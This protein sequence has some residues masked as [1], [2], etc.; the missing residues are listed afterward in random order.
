MNFILIIQPDIRPDRI[1]GKTDWPD[2]RPIQYPVQPYH[3]IVFT[4]QSFPKM[5]ACQDLQL[6]G[7]R[8]KLTPSKNFREGL[9]LFYK[10]ANCVEF[11]TGM[12][13]ISDGSTKQVA[14]HVCGKIGFFPR[15]KSDLMTL[16]L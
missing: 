15:K 12:V 5:N 13:H 14:P 6:R 8:R 10:P 11:V 1:S 3:D 16:V 2:I 7:G 9:Y 4:P